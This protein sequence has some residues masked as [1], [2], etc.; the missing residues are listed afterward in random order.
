MQ[1]EFTKTIPACP[2][3]TNDTS[4]TSLCLQRFLPLSEKPERIY[5]DNSKESIKALSSFAVKSRHKT[6][7]S[8][9]IERSGTAVAHVQSGLQEV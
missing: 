3:K 2:M 5:T 6:P 8:L 7:S 9:R 1:D 4:E